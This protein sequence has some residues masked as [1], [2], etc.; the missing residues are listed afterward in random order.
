LGHNS[1]AA[2]LDGGDC[3]ANLAA[4]AHHNDVV[5]VTLVDD[6]PR[7]TEPRNKHCGATSDDEIDLRW[8]VPGSSRQEV[9][10]EWFGGDR[11]NCLH[12]RHDSVV[13]HRGRTKAPKAT[14]F[15]HC[16]NYFAVG[17]PAH[18]GEHYWV[19]D[20]EEFGQSRAHPRI[21]DRVWI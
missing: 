14:T 16:G 8:H 4:H 10:A 19:F 2:S 7:H 11:S 15:G 9:N 12:L 18:S 5:V 17:N 3:V 20:V 13:A 1:V 21:V 6:L